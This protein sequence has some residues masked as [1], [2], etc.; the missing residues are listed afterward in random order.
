MIS[1]RQKLEK[2][3]AAKL[4]VK[5]RLRD[6]TEASESMCLWQNDEPYDNS[7][8]AARPK[9]KEKTRG[10]ISDDFRPH[11]FSTID[12][13]PE[14]Q[15]RIPVKSYTYHILA[16]MLTSSKENAYVMEINW[17]NFGAAMADTGFS[18]TP[19]GVSE[20]V[21]KADKELKQARNWNG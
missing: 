1:K 13:E 3:F 16:L 10:S 8:V 6:C 4:Q 15:L 14:E 9:R 5:E 21:F 18:C 19:K 12:V 17:N 7:F 2:I 11:L 20:F